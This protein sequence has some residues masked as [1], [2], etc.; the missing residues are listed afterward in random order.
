MHHFEVPK[1]KRLEH[2]IKCVSEVR[3]SGSTNVEEVGYYTLIIDFEN[4]D[5]GDKSR[6]NVVLVREYQAS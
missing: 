1:C 5:G 3:V 4:A 2:L 6:V